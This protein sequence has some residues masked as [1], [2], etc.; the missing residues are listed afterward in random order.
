MSPDRIFSLANAVALIGW[1]V[2]ILLPF[3]KDR[4]KYLAGIIV[5]LL[6]I[7]YTWLIFTAIKPDDLKSFGSLN[8]VMSLFTDK[9]LVTAGWVHYLAFDLFTGIFICRNA[10]RHGINHW[11]IAPILFFT[12]MLGPLGLL[13]YLLLR[14]AVTK[15]YFAENL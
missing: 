14:W 8:G 12:F 3:W 15:N 6:C 2:L 1:A 5:M 13:L 7:T 11:L 9:Q 10:Q 4:E